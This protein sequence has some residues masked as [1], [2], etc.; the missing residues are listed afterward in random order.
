[1]MFKNIKTIGQAILYGPFMQ[2]IS[3]TVIKTGKNFFASPN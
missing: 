3:E 1:M 2:F